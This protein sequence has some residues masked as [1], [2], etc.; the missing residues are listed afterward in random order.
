MKF[1][2]GLQR[3]DLRVAVLFL[4]SL[5]LYCL[6]VFFMNG[7]IRTPDEANFL[8]SAQN[9]IERK[10]LIINNSWYELNKLYDT[11]GFM[12]QHLNFIDGVGMVP[13]YPPGMAI[14]LSVVG[15][16]LFGKL[17][18]VV[19]T[20]GAFGVVL[21]YYLVKFNFNREIAFTSALLLSVLPIYWYWSTITFADVPSF[22]CLIGALLCLDRSIHN[23]SGFFATLS[24]VLLGFLLWLKYANV[25]LFPAIFLY[26]ILTK[27]K[28]LTKWNVIYGLT[29]LFV[30]VGGLLVYHLIVYGNPLTT[31]YEINAKYAELGSEKIV[32]GSLPDSDIK[33]S[34]FFLFK[35]L[36]LRV[37]FSHIINF[38]LQ[39]SVAMPYIIFG[40]CGLVV[41]HRQNNTYCIFLLVVMG[42][43]IG[44]YGN[45]TTW[46]YQF[47]EMSLHSSYLRYLLP[48]FCLL[49]ISTITALQIITRNRYARLIILFFLIAASISVNISQVPRRNLRVALLYDMPEKAKRVNKVLRLTNEGS[50]V[51]S[52]YLTKH[53]LPDRVPA[54]Y[55]YMM[56]SDMI[57]VSSRLLENNVEVNFI[58]DGKNSLKIQSY[59]AAFDHQLLDEKLKIYRILRK[60]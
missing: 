21:F 53:L 32:Q 4:W 55:P 23:G 12:V 26:F 28:V 15:A 44:F 39:A 56:T 58:A 52:K 19:P 3:F 59:L 50:V 35:A 8:L 57:R 41:L 45:F 16:L 42:I 46:G 36:K 17:F 43:L 47:K 6:P 31:G 49:T 25:I 20:M 14:L 54:Y 48:G 29:A 34:P 40:L 10:T 11:Y 30:V 5:L 2:T 27:R 18:F 9:L 38:P 1:I 37:L 7:V 22:V 13:Q 60:R 33:K 51:M 24:G